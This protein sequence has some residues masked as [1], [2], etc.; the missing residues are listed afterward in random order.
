MKRLLL[1]C[2]LWGATVTLSAQAPQWL[3]SQGRAASYPNESYLSG[4]AMSDIGSG[5]PH[6]TACERASKAAA[7]EVAAS[8]RVSIESVTQLETHEV[9][10]DDELHF[11]QLYSDYT[12]QHANAEIVGLKT[13]TYVAA[14][15]G[16]VYA[17]A[18][19]EIAEL[20]SY[21]TSQIEINL[22]KIADAL[23][24]ANTAAKVGEKCKA[25]TYCEGAIEPLAKAEYAQDLLSA[26]A[27]N[28]K[29]S[30]QIERCSELKRLL[31]SK[32]IELEQSTYI[33]IKATESNFGKASTLLA[34][35]LKSLLATKGCSFTTN[36]S[37]ADYLLSIE[38]TTRK[39]D[40]ANPN[41]V[42]AY[43]D[44]VVELYSNHRK[45][46][47]YADE[48]AIKGGAATAEG[49]GRKALQSAADKVC[50]RLAPW[51]EK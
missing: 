40:V 42:Y 38:A 24:L 51:I 6:D 11:T 20:A 29:Q 18:Y 26:I 32:N 8:V 7:S 47:Q 4:F 5:E 34:N 2:C 44:V 41:F 15:K 39:H 10:V 35:R 14:D 46:S 43:A 33:C 1:L 36:E 16:V 22:T 49:A 23:S 12:Q 9:E 25:T 48:L 19:V 27:P 30:L 3:T 13:A 50:Q 21:Y 28:A 37:E 45:G 17:F 31:F